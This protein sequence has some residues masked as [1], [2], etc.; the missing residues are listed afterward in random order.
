MPLFLE[1]GKKLAIWLES[2]E[3]KPIESRPVF[4]VKSLSMRQQQ[5]LGEEIDE[6]AAKP[7]TKEIFEA[8]C[9]L[10]NKYIIG[11]ENMGE[12]VYGCDLQEFLSYHEVRE[13]MRRTMANQYVKIEEKKS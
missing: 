7:T 1:P 8:N 11:W 10:A 4:F 5:T 6:A 13:L 9:E 3:H 12:F 2:D